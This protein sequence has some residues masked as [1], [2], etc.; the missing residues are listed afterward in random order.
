MSKGFVILSRHPLDS[1]LFSARASKL[2]QPR[3]TYTCIVKIWAILTLFFFALYA[4][5][6]ALITQ[7]GAH[8]PVSSN[9]KVKP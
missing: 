6:R 7:A 1:F 4:T 2:D 8:V 9:M 5:A 3:F